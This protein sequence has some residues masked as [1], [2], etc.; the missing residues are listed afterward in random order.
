MPISHV[1]LQLILLSYRW[2]HISPWGFSSPVVIPWLDLLDEAL[3]GSPSLLSSR[4]V[5]QSSTAP[6]VSSHTSE[7]NAEI[8]CS[9]FAVYKFSLASLCQCLCFLRPADFWGFC[10]PGLPPALGYAM[11]SRSILGS[12]LLS[13]DLIAFSQ[14]ASGTGHFSLRFL[15]YTTLVIM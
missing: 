15:L 13:K 12:A 11:L 7:G 6:H 4:L 9:V 10:F 5:P 14:G 8:Y 3:W 2:H 1:A